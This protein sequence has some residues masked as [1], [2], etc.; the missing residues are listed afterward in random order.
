MGFP[1]RICDKLKE[2][3]KEGKTEY[4]FS[5]KKWD[6]KSD[7]KVEIN[8]KDFLIVEIESSQPHPDTNVTKYWYILE[9]NP[10]IKITLIQIF[11]RGFL[12]KSKND[13]RSRL[14]LC[15][16]MAKKMKREFKERFIYFSKK[17]ND[18][19]EIMEYIKIKAPK[20]TANKILT[21]SP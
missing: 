9:K 21:E 15:G 20:A 8:P 11:G 18:M 1:K 7:F 13:Y 17:S 2:Y 4:S 14:E 16:F 5:K 6:F 19:D 3:F 10:D 12:E